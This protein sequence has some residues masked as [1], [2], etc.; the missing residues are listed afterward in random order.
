MSGEPGIGKTTLVET[1]GRLGR[2]SA[3]RQLISRLEL[4]TQGWV[5][6]MPGLLQAEELRRT[7]GATRGPMLRQMAEALEAASA[8][9]VDKALE[10]VE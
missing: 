4:Y 8:G 2:L 5:A 1:F 6:S 3:G 9:G 10:D 7:A